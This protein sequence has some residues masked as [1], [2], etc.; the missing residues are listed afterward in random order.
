MSS[1]TGPEGRSFPEKGSPEAGWS[2][3]NQTEM[4]DA[5]PVDLVPDCG[6][7]RGCGY[8]WHRAKCVL[9]AGIWLVRAGMRLP[10]MAD[11]HPYLGYDTDIGECIVRPTLTMVDSATTAVGTDVGDR[12]EKRKLVH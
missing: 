8:R 11:M 12:T 9:R 2:L 10:T 6:R 3:A 5:W 7:L 1:K 4:L